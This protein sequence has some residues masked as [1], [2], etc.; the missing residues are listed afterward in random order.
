MTARLDLAASLGCDAVEPDNVDGYANDNGLG[1][2]GE[3]QL[4]FNR[5]IAAAAHER[6]L[7]AGLKNDLDQLDELVDYFDWALNEECF[8]YEECHVYAGNFAAQGKAVFHAE[9]VDPARI[10]EVCAVTRP[11][12]LSTLIKNIE[13]DVYQL[14]CP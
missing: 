2:S 11:L 7:S 14:P 8:S 5:F 4:D 3:D 10:E 1:L 12:G 13:L 9:Y 6:G